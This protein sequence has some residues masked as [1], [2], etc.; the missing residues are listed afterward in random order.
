MK[1]LLNAQLLETGR[2]I[3]TTITIARIIHQQQTNL[4]F[5][6]YYV[7]ILRKTCT[8]SRRRRKKE[9]TQ[10]KRLRAQNTKKHPGTLHLD[11]VTAITKI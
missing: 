9:R 1:W 2:H 10:H 7:G 8:I 5:Y 3:G 6:G 4:I 11:A